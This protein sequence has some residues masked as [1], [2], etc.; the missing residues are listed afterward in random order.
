MSLEQRTDLLQRAEPRICAFDIETTKL[1]L[2]FPNAEF[3]QVAAG[4]APPAP[5]IS[6]PA[7]FLSVLS[8]SALSLLSAPAQW[9]CFSAQE[10]TSRLPHNYRPKGTQRDFHRLNLPQMPSAACKPLA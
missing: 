3:D 6:L 2:Q 9:R 4:A 5:H 10:T 1:P 8:C 7:S